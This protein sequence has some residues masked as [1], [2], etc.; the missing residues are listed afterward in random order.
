M[1]QTQNLQRWKEIFLVFNFV[2]LS[3]KSINGNNLIS[4]EK[5]EKRPRVDA[6][7]PKG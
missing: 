2:V 5:G 7:A 6:S 3:E 1:I 4:I